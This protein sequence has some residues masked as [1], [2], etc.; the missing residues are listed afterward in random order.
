[1]HLLLGPVGAGKSTHARAL[2][3]S[4]RAVH[5]DLDDWM[6]R[7]FR[8]DRPDEG[9]VQWYGER[10]D[11]CVAQ[12]WDTALKIIDAGTEVVLEIGMLRRAQRE[13]LYGWVDAAAVDLKVIVLDAE[14]DLRRAR[15]ERRNEER[16][17]TFSMVVPPE[18]FEFAS[19]L[20][21]APEADEIEAREMARLVSCG[22]VGREG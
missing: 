2:V 10:A 1:M 14:R 11:R 3:E 13:R 22:P 19:D 8:P 21:E 17:P 6:A 7:L 15:V 18:V 4:R 12:I 5:L 9:V 20:W 16:G